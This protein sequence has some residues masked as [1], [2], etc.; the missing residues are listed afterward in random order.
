MTP[1][2]A[3]TQGLYSKYMHFSAL[4][5]FSTQ[6]LL[7]KVYTQGD[8]RTVSLYNYCECKLVFNLPVVPNGV[9]GITEVIYNYS[10]LVQ[11]VIQPDSYC[12]RYSSGYPLLIGRKVVV[13]SRFV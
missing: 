8:S 9:P 2:N 12:V 13:H 10:T 4:R 3:D 11:V 6:N 5:R 1:F 7:V